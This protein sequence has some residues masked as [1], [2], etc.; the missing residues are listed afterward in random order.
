LGL[1]VEPNVSS[2]AAGLGQALK[3]K[4]DREALALHAEKRT[5]EV[6]AAEVEQFFVSCLN[7]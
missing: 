4:W 6:V 1:L 5:W 7:K 2:L 3:Q